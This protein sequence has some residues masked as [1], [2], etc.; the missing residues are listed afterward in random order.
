MILQH[1]LKNV[2][3]WR[4]IR[5]GDFIFGFEK[6]KIGNFIAG[7]INLVMVCHLLIV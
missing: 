2:K 1:Y 7:R 5:I 3:E 4:I 6:I